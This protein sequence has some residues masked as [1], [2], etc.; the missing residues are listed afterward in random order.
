MRTTPV[1]KWH[2]SKGRSARPLEWPE[3]AAA[4]DGP[5]GRR[6]ATR[7]DWLERVH[8]RDSSG[9]C[10]V[11][12]TVDMSLDG[13]QVE[14]EG[15]APHRNASL[16][17]HLRSCLP[18]AGARATVIRSR[19]GRQGSTFVHLHFVEPS[20]SRPLLRTELEKRRAWRVQPGDES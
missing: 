14:L 13:A 20:D 2:G 15:P 8:L 7:F 12:F 18:G 4:E 1:E 5:E 6:A 9:T 17:V 16:T 11:G 19:R 3:L 10:R